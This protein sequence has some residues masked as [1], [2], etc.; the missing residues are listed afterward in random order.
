MG[1]VDSLVV[2]GTSAASSDHSRGF[3]MS[4]WSS[5]TTF[6]SSHCCQSSLVKLLEMPPSTT[7][8]GQISIDLASNN[9]NTHIEENCRRHMNTSQTVGLCQKFDVIG[10]TIATVLAAVRARLVGDLQ[11]AVDLLLIDANTSSEL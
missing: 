2:L 4:S 8:Y 9:G 7:P 1:L 6:F 3:V 11:K 10:H 5:Q